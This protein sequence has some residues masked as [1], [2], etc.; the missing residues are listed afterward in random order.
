MAVPIPAPWSAMTR[1][2]TTV[3]LSHGRVYSFATPFGTQFTVG[4]QQLLASPITLVL[5]TRSGGVN[6]TLQTVSATPTLTHEEGGQ[7]VYDWTWSGANGAGA[8]GTITIEADG[9][10]RQQFT[11]TR[12]SAVYWNKIQ[13]NIPLNPSV[14]QY[15][16]Q[17]PR[18]SGST[19]AQD[20]SSTWEFVHQQGTTQSF[21]FPRVIK[22]H[23]GDVGLEWAMETDIHWGS[24]TSGELANGSIVVNPTTGVWE[25]NIC[26]GQ[27]PTS[28]TQNMDFDFWFTPL[29]TRPVGDDTMQRWGETDDNPECTTIRPMGEECP[30]SF[31]QRQGS[32][33]P[34]EGSWGTKGPGNSAET[35]VEQRAR[36]E[37]KGLELAL[38]SSPQLWPDEDA[39][40]DP[41]YKLDDGY[42]GSQY[43]L[44]CAG[45]DAY[46]FPIMD[47]RVAGFQNMAFTRWEK[48]INPISPDNVAKHIYFDQ[49]NLESEPDFTVNEPA[50]VGRY[51]YIISGYR[52]FMRRIY[53][54]AQSYGAKVIQ[55]PQCD[56]VAV[57]H[58][59]ADF[60][61]PGEE[62]NTPAGALTQAQ[63]LRYFTDHVEQRTY[64]TEMSPK[65]MGC[66][67]VIIPRGVKI[68]GVGE[69]FCTENCIAAICQHN[70]GYWKSF[71]NT[72][73]A[74][75]Y[76][77]ALKAFDTE[78]S[79]FRGYWDSTA[80]LYTDDADALV[81]CWRRGDNVLVA[82]TNMT[83]TDR[84]I[85]VISRVATRTPTWRYHGQGI[86]TIDGRAAPGY[87]SNGTA[88]G[89][90]VATGVIGWPYADTY[91]VG[92]ARKNMTMFT[93][94]VSPTVT[95]TPQSERYGRAVQTSGSYGRPPQESDTYER[96]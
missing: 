39:E 57:V 38:Y 24:Y 3:N 89:N 81:A 23:N 9:A 85:T 7:I 66:A 17:F 94:E 62:H 86:S 96:G 72:A 79:E 11:I 54:M 30:S 69:D 83:E 84:D 71:G 21:E 49:T 78:D 25:L 91:T 73:P 64:R 37:A 15:L 53:V 46:T 93:V 19:G 44:N 61:A 33:I 52:E 36:L 2:G 68:T 65:I 92:V 41:S 88:D 77:R 29:P 74:A 51:K 70:L 42:S 1:S 80:W 34:R 20:L 18:Q 63:Q 13:V 27:W 31:W 82:V 14:C 22:V 32:C 8:H 5:Q 60:T 4:G 95:P 90:N 40:Y 48:A 45:V 58:N 47:A 10:I 26:R 16:W 55:H 56:F 50:G 43:T 59:F 67:A 28:G 76:M 75:R 12:S 87:L 6:G 35:F